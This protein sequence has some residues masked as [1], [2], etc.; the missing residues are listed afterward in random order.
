ML[1]GFT[2]KDACCDAFLE[3]LAYVST[4]SFA[5]MLALAS[6]PSVFQARLF[7]SVVISCELGA[8]PVESRFET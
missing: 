8:V 7:S 2:V 5:F 6:Y 4:L 3:P 1:C